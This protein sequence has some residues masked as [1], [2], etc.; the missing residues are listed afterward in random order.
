MWLN[1]LTRF[2]TLGIVMQLWWIK[3]N[4]TILQT[5][6]SLFEGDIVFDQNIKKLILSNNVRFRRKRNVVANKVKLW[7]DGVIPYIIDDTVDTPVRK[8]IRR[9]FRHISKRSC[10]SF[11]PRMEKHKDYITIK[12]GVGCYSSIGRQGGG[13]LLSIVR[14]CEYGA[15][16]E[17]MHALGFFHEQSRPDRDFYVKINWWNIQ[18][19]MERNFNKYSNGV[20]DTLNK[21]YD[22]KS[23]MHYGNKAFSKNGRDTI[24][25]RKHPG[26]KLGVSKERLST[27]DAYQ[28]NQLYKCSSRTRRTRMSSRFCKNIIPGC[29]YYSVESDSCEFNYDFMKHY[30][31]RS[32][33]FC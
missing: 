9:A 4:A 8:R 26:Y 32:C 30:C 23:I 13:Q 22:L 1:K 24:V 14:G 6:P 16:H 29:Y 27:A 28:L 31:R 18:G 17:V 19:G 21:P 20:T 11:I 3:C 5:E 33:G 15:I 10:I 7:P 12:S 2:L 25:S